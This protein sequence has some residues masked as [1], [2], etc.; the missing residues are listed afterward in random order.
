[1]AGS[2]FAA[3]L[4]FFVSSICVSAAPTTKQVVVI[5]LGAPGV[6]YSHV[7]ETEALSPGTPQ[8]V[9][10]LGP[11]SE[12]AFLVLDISALEANGW[13]LEEPKT[14]VRLTGYALLRTQTALRNP[15]EKRRAYA[16]MLG[17]LAALDVNN[18]KKIDSSDFVYNVLRLY[19]DGNSDG[20]IDADELSSLADAEIAEIG[21]IVYGSQK[22]DAQGNLYQAVR[23]KKKDGSKTEGHLVTLKVR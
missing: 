7:Q 14:G 4:F 11:K 20:V 12:D 17:M 16:N 3:S 23:V 15:A 8:S 9:P 10:W 22:K 13:A 2:L 19:R 5:D 6:S 21:F 1:M 18:D